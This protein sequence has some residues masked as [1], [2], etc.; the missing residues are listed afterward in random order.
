MK[1][2]ACLW[3]LTAICLICASQ[4]SPKQLDAYF[5][6]AF[7]TVCATLGMVKRKHPHWRLLLSCCCLWAQK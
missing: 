7:I 3:L 5:E 1:R 2:A 4:V 6:V